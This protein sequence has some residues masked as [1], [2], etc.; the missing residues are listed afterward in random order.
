MNHHP[1]CIHQRIT[2]YPPATCPCCERLR[3]AEQDAYKDAERVC[4]DRALVWAT[5]DQSEFEQDEADNCADDI[6]AR[7]KERK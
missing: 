5:K 7:A 4:R 3:S 6:A 2:F 1:R